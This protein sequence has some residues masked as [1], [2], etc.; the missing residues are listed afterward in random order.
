MGDKKKEFSLFFL[1]LGNMNFGEHALFLC[2]QCDERT[3]SLV[4][5]LHYIVC[6]MRVEFLWRYK[7]V[8]RTTTNLLTMSL[9]AI[10]LL[11]FGSIAKADPYV[12]VNA[13]PVPFGGGGS[14]SM[15]ALLDA[16]FGA[17]VLGAVADQNVTAYWTNTALLFPA[18]TPVLILEAAGFAATNFFGIYTDPDLNDATLNSTLVNIFNGTAAPGCTAAVSW[19][20]PGP[21]TMTVAAGGGCAPLAVNAGVFAG[22]NP[23]AFGFYLNTDDDGDGLPPGGAGI[24]YTVDHLNGGV[25]YA[26]TYRK[27]ATDTWI[28]GFE[29]LAGLGDGDYDD[30]AVRVES[31]QPVSEP[32]SLLLLG[33]GLLGLV[34]MSRR[35]K[36]APTV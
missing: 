14:G 29:D 31:I 26:L 8:R 22:I 27:P 15:Q 28:I 24:V 21:G 30:M 19:A 7:I 36:G 16:S 23:F 1:I 32:A 18:I 20:T 4:P 17:G 9:L 13:R 3:P 11:G 10:S 2:F 6:E 33:T 25:A 5:R 12:P 34:G 35:K